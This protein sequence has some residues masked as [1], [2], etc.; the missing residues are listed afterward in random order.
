MQEERP[1]GWT[2]EA[3]NVNWNI[4]VVAVKVRQIRM[5]EGFL[6]KK[7]KVLLGTNFSTAFFIAHPAVQ[8][9]TTLP[10]RIFLP[11]VL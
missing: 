1:V 9:I 7:L 8:L 3:H 2:D 11:H 5:A 10:T 6:F 4:K